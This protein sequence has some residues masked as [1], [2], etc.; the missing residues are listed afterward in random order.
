MCQTVL[1]TGNIVIKRIDRVSALLEFSVSQK[2]G[3]QKDW[4][5]MWEKI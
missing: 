3:A 4:E 1:G 5:K 2:E